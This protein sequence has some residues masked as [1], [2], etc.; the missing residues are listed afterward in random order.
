MSFRHRAWS[1]EPIGGGS[2]SSSIFYDADGRVVEKTGSFAQ[3]N[4]P[5]PVSGN[6]FNLANEMTA[7]NGTALTY[8]LDGNLINDGT[9]TYSWDA[10]NH[11][12]GITGLSTASF[13]YDGLERRTIKSIGGATTQFLYDGVNPCRNWMV[14]ARRT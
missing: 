6:A 7:F 4:V 8:D 13:V 12:A 5:Q 11:L 3:T 14:A 2:A 9:N 1:F 10:R